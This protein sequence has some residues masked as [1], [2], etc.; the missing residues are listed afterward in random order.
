MI[1]R[2]NLLGTGLLGAAATLF[3]PRIAFA[4]VPTDKRFVFIIQR[5]AADGLGIVVPVGDPA[6]AGQRGMLADV[7]EGG[8]QLDP[9][10]TLHPALAQTGQLYGAG[11]ALFAHAIASPYRER[12]HFDGQNVLE[13]GGSGPYTVKDG[14][15]NR[16]LS[17][18]PP[19]DARA[20]AIAAAIPLALR[21]ARDVASYAPSNLPQAS[22]DL[23][24]RVSMLY[25]DD[26][27]LHG[28]WD[29]ALATR[30]L[31]GDLAA[32]NGRNAAATGDLCARLMAPAEGARIAMIETG[33]WDTHAGQRQRLAGQLRGLDAMIGAIRT[34]LGAEW[35]NTM[36]LVATEFG[37]TVAINGTGGT[38]HG[39]AASAML[40]GG[41][42][43][44]GRV[45]ADWP[46]LAAGSL[47]D[48]RDLRPT[49]DLDSFIA[50]AIAG[51]FALDPA[52][53]RRV[54]FPQAQEGPMVEGLV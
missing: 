53:T 38:D 16:M 37:R 28:L 21:G 39:T 45:I 4:A 23:I 48:G 12:S 49:T 51:H 46:G 52:Q 33:G 15:L 50:G 3:V 44:G 43:K 2:R 6:F 26:A 10:F 54:L 14:W 29:Q 17:L 18:L 41:A 24:E 35:A 47:H 34:G 13:S 5:G 19:D 30:L 25:Q 9:L 22:D 11:Q 36:V 42:V 20:M 7:A 27:Q 40:L 1:D 8:V 32:D 31:T